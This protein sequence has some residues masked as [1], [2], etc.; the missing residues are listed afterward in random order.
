MGSVGWVG[1]KGRE[2]LPDCFTCLT[3]PYRFIDNHLGLCWPL[4]I[5]SKAEFLS[6]A[7]VDAWPRCLF[8]MKGHP[9]NCRVFSSTSLFNCRNWKVSRNGQ[10]SPWGTKITLIE[11]CYSKALIRVFLHSQEEKWV[12]NRDQLLD[13]LLIG[14]EHALSCKL[15]AGQ[16]FSQDTLIPLPNPFC[17]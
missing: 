4:W 17:T 6:F 16:H 1:I 2:L 9:V 8:V 13:L 15:C 5:F 14:D 7:T 3:P 11:N 10:M 12:K